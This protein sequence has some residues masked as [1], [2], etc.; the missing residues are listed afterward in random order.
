MCFRDI[1]RQ[2]VNASENNAVIFTGT[3]CTGAVHKLIHA[4]N[5]QAPPVNILGT[6]CNTMHSQFFNFFCKALAKILTQK[7]RSHL[8]STC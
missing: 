6:I 4:L 7:G 8:K 1:I 5:L 2:A 3:G